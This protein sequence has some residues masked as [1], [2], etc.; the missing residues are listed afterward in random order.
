VASLPSVYRL[1]DLEVDEAHEEVRRAGK[2][3]LLRA[4]PL[5][6]LLYLL[7]HRN[8]LVPKQEL[9][10]HVWPGLTV[11]DAAL[12]SALADLRRAL[13]DEGRSPRLVETHR[14]RGYHWVA[15][16]EEHPVSPLA[17][18]DFVGRGEVLGELAG[19]LDAALAGSGRL[20]LLTG[21]AGIGKTRCAEELARIAGSQGVPTHLAWCQE[22]GGAPAYWPWRQLLGSLAEAG[23]QLP[24]RVAQVLRESPEP[25]P[26]AAAR[27]ANEARFRLFDELAR[28]LRSAADERGLLLLLDDLQWA[29]SSSLAL[30]VYVARE[31][32]RSRILLVATVRDTEVHPDH[33]VAE[34]LAELARAATCTRIALR[35]LERA[36]VQGLVVHLSGAEP[37]EVYVDALLARTDGNPFLV[38]ELVAAPAE[39][40]GPPVP[41]GVADVTR[42][43]LR[44]LS[45]PCREALAYAA[46]LGGDFTSGRLAAVSGTPESRVAEALDEARRADIVREVPGRT[47]YRFAHDLVRE[48]VEA[49][50]P[51]H[52]R[53]RLH[54]RVGEALEALYGAEPGD[55]LAEL[56]RHFDAAGDPARAADYAARAGLRALEIPAREAACAHFAHALAALD[57]AP[58]PD[59]RQRLRVLLAW[60]WACID[61][62][63]PERWR[64]LFREAAEL[65]DRLGDTE[66]LAEAARGFS[67]WVPYSLQDEEGVRLLERA[68]SRLG[69]ADSPSRVMMLARLAHQ[70]EPIDPGPRVDALLDEADAV[71]RRLGDPSALLWADFNRSLVLRQRAVSPEA[72]LA[73]TDRTLALADAAHQPVTARELHTGRTHSYLLLGDLAGAE[74]SVGLVEDAARWSESYRTEVERYRVRRC[75]DRGRLAEAEARIEAL[76]Q[77]GPGVPPFR[78]SGALAQRYV[79]RREQGRL[80]EM[81]PTA[82]ESLRALGDGGRPEVLH[83]FEILALADLGRDGEARALLRGADPH[84]LEGWPRPLVVTLLAEACA[85]LEDEEAA[86]QLYDLLLP[87]APYGADTENGW[88]TLGSSSRI[89]GHLALRL[90]RPADA[91]RHFEDALA[92]D[93]RMEAPLWQMYDRLGRARA[94]AARGGP[95]DRER[96]FALATEALAWARE[97][98]LP[99]LTAHA[100]AALASLRAHRPRLRKG[101]RLG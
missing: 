13:G 4:R 48:A 9:F 19:A 27:E 30:L 24:D 74:R 64:P 61:E 5:H 57:R 43:R 69:P 34:T 76:E 77:H 62:A 65:A 86:L 63:R 36:D 12:A 32:V 33:P 47:R 96:A 99:R 53:A 23:A 51:A 14:G 7:R 60:A 31:L 68:L 82:L 85:L 39:E 71:A 46:T 50:L 38:R 72:Y 92:F 88:V 101:R 25:P 40:E 20:V 93:A 75:I 1:G 35:G 37:D 17:A 6:L 67:S 21:E 94:L 97:R 66:A 84:G 80:A 90:G 41:P 83:A 26:G 10:D 91:E 58:S 2:P 89:L 79:L 100:E 22:G 29:D 70:L 54:R 28:A 56:A 55:G 3:V 42:A 16:V 15:P 49:E 8:R 81:T 45:P 87:L 52:A 59:L 95:E 98:Q 73:A 44:R 11:S 18:A 78:E